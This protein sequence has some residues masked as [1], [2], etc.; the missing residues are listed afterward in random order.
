MV[1]R[2]IISIVVILLFLSSA[3]SMDNCLKVEKE[4]WILQNQIVE[5]SF[6][7]LH[8]GAWAKYASNLKAVYLGKQVSPKTGMKLYVIEFTG[9][10]P[11]GQIWYKLTPKDVIYQGK[12][13]RYWTLE[14]MEAYVL[15]NQGVYYIPKPMIETYMRMTGGNSWSRIL[16]EGII[17]PSSDCWDVVEIKETSYTVSNGRKIKATLI[18]SRENG[19]KLYCSTKVPF[20]MVESVD[21]RGGPDKLIDYGFSG[22]R[23]KITK[24][25]RANAKPFP[26]PPLNGNINP[27]DGFP[28][29][30]F[31]Q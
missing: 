2:G 16:K 12:I 10:G 22:G 19:G 28:K 9:E 7:E 6:K 25:M 30:P 29:F 21:S 13:F 1:K 4:L 18:R 24:S 23:A 8:Y 5:K 27:S 3:F 31:K 14:P 26:V 11:V 17:L 15:K 20:G